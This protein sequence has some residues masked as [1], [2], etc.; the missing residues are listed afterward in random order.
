MVNG[1]VSSSY[2]YVA[3][4]DYGTMHAHLVLVRRLGHFYLLFLCN[5]SLLCV[6]QQ[7]YI[8]VV[9]SVFIGSINKF[10]FFTSMCKPRLRNGQCDFTE[11]CPIGNRLEMISNLAKGP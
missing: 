2:Q 6:E 11:T 7:Y 3:R 1:F 10:D 8:V 4:E 9:V 5:I